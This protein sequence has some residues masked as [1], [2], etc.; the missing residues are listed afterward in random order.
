LSEASPNVSTSSPPS[1]FSF[2]PAPACLNTYQYIYYDGGCN[3]QV[4]SCTGQDL[5][6]TRVTSC[7][8]P[9]T[10]S[11]GASI[12]GCDQNCPRPDPPPATV[13]CTAG[14]VNYVGST[15]PGSN[16]GQTYTCTDGTSYVRCL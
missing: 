14:G 9:G 2:S 8:S 15:C 11:S 10:D 4:R 1:T 3:Y 12:P 5:G 7:S 6:V 16:L 13:T